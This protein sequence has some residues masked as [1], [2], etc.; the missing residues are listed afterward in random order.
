M[1]VKINFQDDIYVIVIPEHTQLAYLREKVERKIRMAGHVLSSLDTAASA[2]G[3]SG[4]GA[5]ASGDKGTAGGGGLKMKYRDEDG[6]LITMQSD[7][8]VA[9]AIE[10]VLAD[11]GGGIAALSL[12]V[13][14]R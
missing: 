3:S 2:P 8:D 7:E 13:T 10:G 14:S 9:M 12:I 1:K 6:D 11:G 4:A 5:G